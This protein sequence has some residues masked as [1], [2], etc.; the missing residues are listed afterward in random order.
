MQRPMI[1]HG[2]TPLRGELKVNP[3]KNAALPIL[4]GSLL[5]REPVTLVE[6]PRLRDIEVLLQL[7]SHLGTRYA[8]EGRTLHLHTPEIKTTHAPYELVSKMR[9]SFI[10]LGALL[11]REGEGEVSMPGGC[12][13]GPRPVDLH[14]KALRELGFA[15]EEENGTFS[16]RR[17]RYP[18]GEVVFDRPTVG[19]TE[20]VMLAAALGPTEVTIVNAALEPEIVDFANFLQMLGVQIEGAG[21]AKMTIRGAES[22]GGGTYTIIPDRIEAGTYLLAA[23]ATRGEILLEGA[24]PKHMDALISKL[25]KSGHTIVTGTD[26]V[27]LKSAANPEPFDVDAREY[28]GFPTDLQPPVSAYLATVPGV[29]LVRDLVYPD[30]F[31]H[32]GELARLGAELHLKERVLAVHG[33]SLSGAR[34]KAFDIRGGGAMVIAALAAEGETIIEGMQHISR[35]YENLE[36]RLRSLGAT[37]YGE[38]V[39]LEQAAD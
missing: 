2:G 8:W 23:A 38:P 7:L 34:V 33:R 39:K 13:F 20:Q 15:V 16:A 9:A 19:G 32:V 14:I 29:S 24:N 36:E 27:R 26:W 10:V 22:L 28:P 12:A 30:R 11:A 3:A 4:V 17:S 1:I 31:T 37:V 25:R 5:T 35:G 21:T 18:E 6:V